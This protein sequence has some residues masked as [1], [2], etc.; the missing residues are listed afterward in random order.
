M[1]DGTRLV[2]AGKAALSLKAGIALVVI[3]AFVN[4]AMLSASPCVDIGEELWAALSLGCIIA[5]GA[6][7]MLAGIAFGNAKS[8]S[9]EDGTASGFSDK[10]SR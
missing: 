9:D 2:F 5:A 10:E 6:G 4:I 8:V 3:S 1:A 7:M